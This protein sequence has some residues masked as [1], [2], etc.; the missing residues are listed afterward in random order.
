[1]YM[2]RKEEPIRTVHVHVSEPAF[3]YIT[4]VSKK[5]KSSKH[6]AVDTILQD[7]M[8]KSNNCEV[9]DARLISALSRERIL[10]EKC[11]ELER[12]NNTLKDILIRAGMLNVA[13]R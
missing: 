12:E 2:K 13:F 4:K 3:D 9:L 6:K 11:K 5:V 7:Y 1:M 8:E 10:K